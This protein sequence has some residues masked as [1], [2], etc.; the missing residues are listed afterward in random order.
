[1]H[2]LVVYRDGRWFHHLEIVILSE[3]KNLRITSSLVIG[4]QRQSLT[5]RDARCNLRSL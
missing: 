3:A 2:E 1:V 4:G 5:V